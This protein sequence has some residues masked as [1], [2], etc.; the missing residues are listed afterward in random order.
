MNQ[1]DP[2]YALGRSDAEYR[3]LNEQAEFLRP[4]TERLFISA[5]IR[6][7]MRV[8]DIGSGVGDVALLAA[9][10]VGTQGHVV[11][12]D[13][14]SAALEKARAR[15]AMLGVSNVEF[16]HGDVRTA[17]LAGD[18]DAA[19]G[20]LVLMYFA[21]PADALRTVT[22]RVKRGGRIVFHEMVMDPHLTALSASYPS[23]SLWT[24]IASTIVRTFAAAGVHIQM[25]RQL[26][27]AYLAAG[28]PFPSMVLEC[29]VGGGPDFAAYS[30]LANTMRSLAP[31]AER[32]GLALASDL[33]L[34]TLADRLRD[35]AVATGLLVSSPPFI[36]A[37][38]VNP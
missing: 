20:R 16:I 22:G 14:D 25:G 37:Y 19:V 13:L 4:L 29:L 3:R 34:D 17:E 31:L 12:I 8:L 36:G 5:G 11:G 23:E 6:P 7:G 9:S 30:W 18:F 35:E 24:T 28:L 32:M 21:D 33:E 38:A 15:A 1:I 26:P 2:T 10:I 27:Q